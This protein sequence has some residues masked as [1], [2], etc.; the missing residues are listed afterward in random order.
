M[1]NFEK[2]IIPG[3]NPGGNKN[4]TGKMNSNVSGEDLDR[5]FE[6]GELDT[7]NRILVQKTA[8]EII[9]LIKE[10]QNKNHS[11]L[12]EYI[13]QKFKLIEIPTI[14]LKDT[15]WYKLTDGEHLGQNIQGFK[16]IIDENGNKKKIPHVAFSS[17]VDYL[18][19]LINRMVQRLKELGYFNI[20]NSNNNK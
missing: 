16:I 4:N 8:E 5:D 12:I 6:Y 19:G 11:E 15:L 13:Q 1:L 14:D 20:I 17:D 10:S 3:F 9:R 2:N 18:D 7:K